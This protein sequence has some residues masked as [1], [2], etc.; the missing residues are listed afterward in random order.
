MEEMISSNNTQTFQQNHRKLTRTRINDDLVEIFVD[1]RSETAK[2]KSFPVH[3]NVITSSSRVLKDYF[4]ESEDAI[5]LKGQ[6]PRIV[7]SYINW[8]YRDIQTCTPAQLAAPRISRTAFNLEYDRL[9]KLYILGHHLEDH[10]LM[11]AVVDSFLEMLKS[12]QPTLFPGPSC[13]NILYSLDNPRDR[14]RRLLVK[15]YSTCGTAASVRFKKF[16][17][18]REFAE[19]LA[20]SLMAIRDQNRKKLKDFQ[21]EEF[22]IHD[23]E[24]SDRVGLGQKRNREDYEHDE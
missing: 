23:Q 17:W 13:I 16:W 7:G 19:D 6:E 8:L 14:L 4:V 15:V 2:S 1:P 11:D 24:N 3:R 20:C 21:S 9:I 22:H 18:P 12:R 10:N 5:V